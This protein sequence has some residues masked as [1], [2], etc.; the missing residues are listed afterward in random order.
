MVSLVCF[1][2]FIL[3]F[4][5]LVCANLVTITPELGDTFLSLNTAC[6]NVKLLVTDTVH[7]VVP[8]IVRN[9]CDPCPQYLVSNAFALGTCKN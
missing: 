9:I 4:R 8:V 6:W 5:V 3:V 7:L 2:G 1:G